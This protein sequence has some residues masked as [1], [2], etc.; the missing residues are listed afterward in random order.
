M[1]VTWAGLPDSF[2]GFIVS[3]IGVCVWLSNSVWAGM[4]EL[5]IMRAGIHWVQRQGSTPIWVRSM[6]TQNKQG[7]GS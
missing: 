5:Q 2:P 7:T 4:T 3:N 1:T 6:G